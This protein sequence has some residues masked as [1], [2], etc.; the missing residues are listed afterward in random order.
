MLPIIRRFRCAGLRALLAAGS[1]GLVLP[2]AAQAPVSDTRADAGKTTAPAAAAP[3]ALMQEIQCELAWLGD[4]ATF[5][6]PL[7]AQVRDNAMT[8]SGMVPSEAARKKAME[9]A[10]QC[11]ALP[12]NDCMK[13]NP[14]MKMSTS[15]ASVEHMLGGVIQVLHDT[16]GNRTDAIEISSSGD[17]HVC[18]QGT[19]ASHEEK[20][21]VS[22]RMR[23]VAGCNCV[24]NKLEVVMS[25]PTPAKPSTFATHRGSV[26]TKT[27]TGPS[28]FAADRPIKKAPVQ[29]ARV[30]PKPLPKAEVKAE[31]KTEKKPEMIRMVSNLEQPLPMPVSTSRPAPSSPYAVKSPPAMPAVASPYSPMRPTTVANDWSAVMT[32]APLPSSVKRSASSV[33]APMPVGKPMASRMEKVVPPTMPASWLP[34]EKS[35]TSK[36]SAGRPIPEKPYVT[37]GWVVLD[38]EPKVSKPVVPVVATTG[39]NKSSLRERIMAMCPGKVMDVEVVPGADN[40]ME[41]KIKVTGSVQEEVSTKVLQLPEIASPSVKLSFEIH[42]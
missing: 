27:V 41:V 3:R 7:K 4:P 8:V 6:C 9:L 28:D 32:V 42:D 38:E 22:Q 33:P 20:L 16:V 18:L 35:S 14:D 31:V 40:T 1:L 2:A 17:G 15:S 12:L 37:A 11:T 29:Q 23:Q 36:P 34:V 5:H 13:V 26:A 30:E 39:M 10:R 21:A 19:I 25:A 24:E